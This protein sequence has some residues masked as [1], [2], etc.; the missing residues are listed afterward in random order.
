MTKHE[1][2]ACRMFLSDFPEN[3]TF[4]RV[5]HAIEDDG[6]DRTDGRWIA[7]WRPLQHMSRDDLAEAIYDAAKFLSTQYGEA[8]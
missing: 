8:A 4:D 5:L 1:I 6:D 2:N 3:W 7:V